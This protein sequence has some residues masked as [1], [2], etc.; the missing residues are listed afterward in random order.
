MVTP[1]TV[2]NWANSGHLPAHTTVGG[3]RRFSI[4]DVKALAERQGIP[5]PSTFSEKP[6]TGGLKL[7]V[8][9]DDEVFCRFVV[10]A[11]KGND[12]VISVDTAADGFEAGQKLAISKPDFVL[13]DL[14]MPGINGIE[15][16]SRIKSDPKTQNIVVIF[17][18]GRFDEST[19]K[20]AMQEGAGAFLEKPLRIATLIQ[21]L[22]LGE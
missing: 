9:D 11:L 13:L 21:A 20:Q 10:E 18:S 22:G 15:V 5:L 8:V 3:H 6:V 12:N 17:V 7:L 1:G 2:R 4:V 16:C 14:Q 19:R